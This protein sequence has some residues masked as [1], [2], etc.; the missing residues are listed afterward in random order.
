MI[1][2]IL[3]KVGGRKTR[4]SNGFFLFHVSSPIHSLEKIYLIQWNNR[5]R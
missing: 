5:K 1:A 3:N 4:I 2:S